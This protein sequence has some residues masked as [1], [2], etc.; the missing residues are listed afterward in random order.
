LQIA[1]YGTKL[2]LQVYADNVSAT[3]GFVD[4]V[5]WRN[6]MAISNRARSP[7]PH[8]EF[9]A[10][11][12]A[13]IF[14]FAGCATTQNV[15]QIDRLESVGENPTILLMPP[16]IRYYL[17]TAGGI[18][19]P[20]AEWT[21]AARKNF[22]SA[23]QDFAKDIGTNL[24]VMDDSDMTP[25][26]VKYAKLHRAVGFTV[27]TNHFGMLKL[28][29]KA[30]RFD[31]S[32]GPGISEVAEDY[33]A[34]YGLFTY[35]RDEQAS[36]GRVALAVLAAVAGGSV[37]TGSEYGFASLVDLK[38]GDVVWFNVVNAGSGELRNPE[39]AVTAVSTLF[40]DIPTNR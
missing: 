37:S 3:K 38:T 23:V 24:V 7:Q 36:G 30:G 13:S 20:H 35:Y 29:T 21:E 4:Q 18:S 34:D 5:T 6:L 39:G 1:G 25:L 26:E 31:W 27:L 40:K 11:L 16:D 2:A 10:V 12:I 33:D 19:E 9:V 28:P 15:Q 22:S 17:I 8:L 32:L 14:L